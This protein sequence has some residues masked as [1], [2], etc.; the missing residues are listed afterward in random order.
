MPVVEVRLLIDLAERNVCSKALSWLC[1]R[2]H[3]TVHGHWVAGN[4]R[5]YACVHTPKTRCG[6]PLGPQ[7]P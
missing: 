2:K 1:G 5:T 4:G 3:S 7:R 6:P